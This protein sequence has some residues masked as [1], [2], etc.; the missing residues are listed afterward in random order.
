MPRYSLT[1]TLIRWNGA[2]K[3]VPVRSP[4]TWDLSRPGS[5]GGTRVA[6]ALNQS[7]LWPGPF[8]T[9]VSPTP[10][11]A[12]SP[13]R[14]RAIGLGQPE[15]ALRDVVERHLLGD[16][17]DPEDAEVPPVPLHVV[18]RLS[19]LEAGRPLLLEGGPALAHVGGGV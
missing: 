16:G 15:D 7:A 14:L 2:T 18:H 3:E 13:L 10:T 1:A 4:S 17:G 9:G 5:R 12:T 11:M 8:P 19:P 6:P